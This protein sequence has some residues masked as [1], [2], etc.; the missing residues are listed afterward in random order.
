MPWVETWR[1]LPLHLAAGTQLTLVMRTVVTRALE[2]GPVAAAAGGWGPLRP[3]AARR[4]RRR[5]ALAGA[6][7]ASS[8][9]S[10]RTLR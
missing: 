7:G 1:G 8:T 2:V 3:P 6:Q 4:R 9:A 5:R 10:K